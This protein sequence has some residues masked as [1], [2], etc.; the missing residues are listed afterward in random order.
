[1]GR[2][3]LERLSREELIE[4]VLRLQRPAKTSRTDVAELITSGDGDNQ[5]VT[6][7]VRNQDGS[8]VYTGTLT[9]AGSRLDETSSS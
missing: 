3:E 6:V 5:A 1:M 4:L 7:M 8:Q 2:S 9:F